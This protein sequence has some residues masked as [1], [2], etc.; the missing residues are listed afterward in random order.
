MNRSWK[1][2]NQLMPSQGILLVGF[3]LS[4]WIGFCFGGGDSPNVPWFSLGIFRVPQ[5]LCTGKWEDWELS[6]FPK[7]MTDPW[8]EVYLPRMEWL[9][10]A[11]W[12]QLVQANIPGTPTPWQSCPRDPGSPSQNGFMERKKYHAFRFGDCT[13]RSSSSDVWWARIPTTMSQ[14]VSKWL[15]TYL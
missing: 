8:D 4:Q 13:S 14:E 7:P 3:V 9:S 10:F 2:I 6:I 1:Y 15:I 11:Y 5:P 12:N